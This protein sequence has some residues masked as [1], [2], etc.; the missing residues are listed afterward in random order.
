VIGWPWTKSI[1]Q[2]EITPFDANIDNKPPRLTF[3]VLC[4][5]EI[6]S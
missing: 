1:R 6:E 4:N 3:K 5:S 2:I